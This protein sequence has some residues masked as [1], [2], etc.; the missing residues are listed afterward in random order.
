MKRFLLAAILLI[1]LSSQAAHIKGGFFTYQYL[2]PGS[3][4]NL[5]YR[6]TL[7]V[8]MICNPLPNSGQLSN[9]INFSIFDPITN[10]LVQNPSVTITNQYQLSKVYDEPCITGDQRFCYY[11]IVVYDLPSIE[12]PATPQGYIV[13]YQR[14]CRIAG[15]NNVVGS[16]AVGN[17]FFTMIPGTAVAPGAE[18]NSSPVFPIN[19]T[20]VVC[21]NSYFQYSFQASDIDGDSLSY[22][23]CSAYQG[24]DQTNSAPN[25]A[26]NPPYQS[27]PYQAPFSGIQPMGPGVSINNVTG[28]IS[29]TAPDLPGQ[30]VLCVCINEYR[31]GVWI[32]TTRKELHVDVGNCDPLRAQ[33]N[34][35]MLTCDGFN[36]DFSNLDA[37]NPPGTE[38]FWSFDDPSTGANNTSTLA[39]P[40]HVFSDTGVYNVKLRVSLTGGLCAD[41][42]TMVVKVYP[43]FFPGF[44]VNGS[45]FNNPFSFT[46]TTN[47]RYGV[48]N[49]WSWNFG[50][51][52]TLADT[53]RIRNPQWTYP[54]P[55]PRDV[56]LIVT[57]SKGC[58]DTATVTIN[59][60]DK[61]ALSLPFRDT[62]ICRN[63]RIDLNAVGTGQF[64]WTG[65]QIVTAANTS[66]ITVAPVNTT[67]YYVNLTDLGCVNRDSIQVRVVNAVSLRAINDTTIC[68]G[69]P[70]QLNATTDGLSYVWTPAANLSNP[71]ILNPI[72]ITSTTTTY[73][74]VSTVGSCSATDQVLVTTVPYPKAN[75][76]PDQIVCYNGSLQLN[77]THD[78]TS[79]TWSPT[80]YLSSPAVLNPIASPP[81]TTTYIF[82]SFDTKGCPK[83]GRDT[84]VITLLPRVRANAG[85]DTSVVVGQPLQLNGSGGVT[86]SWSPSTGLNNPSIS[87]PIGT[88]TAA[89]DTIRYKLIVADAAGCVDSAFVVVKI[90]QVKPTVFVPT[91]F[92]PNNDGLNDVVRPICVGID[93]LEYFSVFNRWGQLVYKTTADKAGWD[94]RING[95]LQDSGVFVWMVSAVDYSGNKIFLKGTV[96]LIR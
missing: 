16:G 52:A 80:N 27:I 23:F 42:A 75:L 46:D 6:I 26:S 47:T 95:R 7:N 81:R 58:V 33:L 32:S 91:A 8:Y 67:W 62:L 70:I 51:L 65:P 86:Y 55:G 1:S 79:F 36:V 84:I 4:T 19:D 72:A 59:V 87:N 94:G 34:P 90:F 73:T 88:Y 66:T 29:G 77:A 53:S 5:R 35:T 82:S 61:P 11:Y 10:Q 12:L 39:T 74:I 64:N 60:L 69:D 30:Y 57:N 25:P 17:T 93:H 63:D 43:G 2:G 18:T 24:G 3:G 89:E 68:Q 38:Y 41:S 21:R 96:A 85:R 9:P 49:S 76:G 54:G 15:I 71:N 31:N 50:D 44:I 48:V 78:G 28:L 20:A 83:P 92:T 37:S 14:C 45:C 40:T 13:S 22:S 56:Q